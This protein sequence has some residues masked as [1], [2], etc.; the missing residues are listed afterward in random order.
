MDMDMWFIGAR[1]DICDV[2]AQGR[3]TDR[4]TERQTQPGHNRT[5]NRV[6]N[7]W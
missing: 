1:Y 7:E 5:W 2:C 3:D 6:V 4:Q